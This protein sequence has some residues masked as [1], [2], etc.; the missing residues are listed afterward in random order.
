MAQLRLNRHGL[1]GSGLLSNA[2]I[3]VGEA[4]AG[5][6]NACGCRG[7]VCALRTGSRCSAVGELDA[8]GASGV[9]I[10]AAA[11]TLFIR[12]YQTLVATAS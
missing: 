4:M 9:G 5:F 1:I 7:A 11:E 6:I 12:R 10:V 2:L 8:A 3:K